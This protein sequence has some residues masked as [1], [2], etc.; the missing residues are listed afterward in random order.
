[1]ACFTK[2]INHCNS[3]KFF[4]A[5]SSSYQFVK[6]FPRHC[7]ALYSNYII[8]SYSDNEYK[9]SSKPTILLRHIR[10][11]QCKQFK[12]ITV[13]PMS[14]I[15]ILIWIV[16]IKVSPLFPFLLSVS[17]GLC[18]SKTLTSTNRER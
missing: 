10:S 4:P 14:K 2:K 8:Y 7:F 5:N 11:W 16:S 15:F 13:S 1:M 9:I 3:L 6:V 17:L 12:T 18:I